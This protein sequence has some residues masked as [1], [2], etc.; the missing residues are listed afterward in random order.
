MR[1]IEETFGTANELVSCSMSADTFNFLFG[2]L[3]LT[4]CTSSVRLEAAP[5]FKCAA[6]EFLSSSRGKTGLLDFP[7]SADVGLFLFRFFFCLFGDVIPLLFTDSGASCCSTISCLVNLGDLLLFFGFLGVSNSSGGSLLDSL[8]V[9][10][11][12]LRKPLLR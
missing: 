11:S 7:L 6:E 1:G 12:S 10:T 4:D 8:G 2:S 5:D 9:P 3:G